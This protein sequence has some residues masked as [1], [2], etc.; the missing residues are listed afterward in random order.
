[1]T[2]KVMVASGTSG[3]ISPLPEYYGKTIKSGEIFTAEITFPW[4]SPSAQLFNLAGAE[5]AAGSLFTPSGATLVDLQAD[6]LYKVVV[7]LRSNG[8][9]L[10]ETGL[11]KFTNAIFTIFQMLVDVV[12]IVAKAAVELVKSAAG[13]LAFLAQYWWVI[14]IVAFG[15]LILLVVY[16]PG[17]VTSVAKA[18]RPGV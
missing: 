7:T 18:A 6:G 4:T 10:K 13:A 12:I 5:Q 2:E 8:L 9:V 15:L 3:S 1:M 17:V 14:L 16:R 11:Q